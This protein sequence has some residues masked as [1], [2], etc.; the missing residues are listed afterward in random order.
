[1]TGTTPLPP[2]PT[3]VLDSAALF[4]VPD[5]VGGAYG[6]N[7]RRDRAMLRPLNGYGDI[8]ARDTVKLPAPG[9]RRDRLRRPSDPADRILGARQPPPRVTRLLER[10]AADGAGPFPGAVFMGPGL[11]RDD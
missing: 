7:A 11:R 5:R 1:M 10:V 3:D 8:D 6:A 4:C 9:L 2:S